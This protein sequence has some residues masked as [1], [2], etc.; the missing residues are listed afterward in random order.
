VPKPVSLIS[1]ER[2]TL[3]ILV[4]ALVTSLLGCRLGEFPFREQYAKFR[5]IKPGR[6]EQQ[7][8]MELGEP[9]YEYPRGVSPDK[10]CVPGWVCDRKEI[11]HKL[12]IY[13]AGEPIAYVYFNPNGTVEHVYVGG[14]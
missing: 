5:S 6:T 4:V 14:S 1:L 3:P 10:Y 2:G 13:K 8:R 7:V 9:A 12:L 11:T